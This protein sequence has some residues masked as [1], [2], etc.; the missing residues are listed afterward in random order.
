MF[1]NNNIKLTQYF[2]V[3]LSKFQ[4]LYLVVCATKCVL[5]LS[6]LFS[7]S[8]IPDF[9]KED[10]IHWRNL[11]GNKT[12]SI[13]L[14]IL[15]THCLVYGGQ[16][17]LQKWVLPGRKALIWIIRIQIRSWLWEGSNL[18]MLAQGCVQELESK[19]E[20]QDCWKDNTP[21]LGFSI[22]WYHCVLDEKNMSLGGR[23]N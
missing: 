11:K 4:K 21:C 7:N 22:G 23:S 17:E 20:P 18:I 19:P 9:L 2:W 1:K 6:N 12:K 10:Y 5:H 8:D 13:K 14:E 15:D 3:P 16:H